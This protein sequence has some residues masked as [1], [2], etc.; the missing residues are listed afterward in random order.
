[1]TNLTHDEIIAYGLNHE[2]ESVREL[3]RRFQDY[4]DVA[5]RLAMKQTIN[6]K[7]GKHTIEGLVYEPQYDGPDDVPM[8]L[9]KQAN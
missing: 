2:D 4:R 6:G 1:M 5:R 3:A 7:F 9:K 8:F